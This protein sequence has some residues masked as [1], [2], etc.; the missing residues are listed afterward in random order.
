MLDSLI[1][2]KQVED[3]V[4]KASVL[5]GIFLGYKHLMMKSSMTL[6]F[7]VHSIH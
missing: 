3:G 6:P 1:V 2:M 4:E 5:V 7:T